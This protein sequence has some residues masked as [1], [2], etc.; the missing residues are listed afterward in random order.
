[1]TDDV[2]S[3]P[4]ALKKRTRQAT[5]IDCSQWE[6]TTAGDWT[7]GEFVTKKITRAASAANLESAESQPDFGTPDR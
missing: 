3:G 2:E 1:M 4:L 7:F 6:D 5:V